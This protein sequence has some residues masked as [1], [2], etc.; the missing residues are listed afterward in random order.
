MA[1]WM[2]V[3]YGSSQWAYTTSVTWSICANIKWVWMGTFLWI[4]ADVKRLSPTP[5]IAYIFIWN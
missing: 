3:L 2:L 5:L 4:K 1:Y